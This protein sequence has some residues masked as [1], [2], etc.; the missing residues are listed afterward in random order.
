M[1][2][3]STLRGLTAVVR[4]NEAADQLRES[5]RTFLERAGVEGADLD[6]LSGLGADRL[7]VYR[8]LVF[9]RFIDAVEM[10]IPRT[11]HRRGRDALK[12]DVSMFLDVEGS[13]SPYLRDIAT[14]FVRWVS[15]LWLADPDVPNYLPELARHELLSFETASMSD[16]SEQLAQEQL[17]LERGVA[18]QRATK[19]AHYDYAV[20]QLPANEEDR[21]EPL[22]EPTSLLAY[23]DAEH[24]VRYLELGPVSA[25][26]LTEL[27]ERATTLREAIARGCAAADVQIDDE[28]LGGIAQLLAELA[29][30][31]VL[32]GPA[33]RDS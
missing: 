15:P 33:T 2:P 10:T 12:A 27:L 6:Q 14:E 26:V 32:L 31:G 16:E 25:A 4:R 17:D 19:V 29:D 22:A 1:Q 20:H 21:T 28:M 23:R 8:R 18:F 11:M 3:E 5:P 13:R 7:L 24:R 9:N 30:R